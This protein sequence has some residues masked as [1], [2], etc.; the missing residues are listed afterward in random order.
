MT[1]PATPVDPGN[2]PLMTLDQV[3]QRLQ[4]SR[5]LLYRL[6][7]KRELVP[8]H[9]GRAIRFDP[10]TVDAFIQRLNEQAREIPD[11]PWQVFRQRRAH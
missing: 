1:L 9:L 7:R 4:V 3:L 2:R 10:N 11:D 5:T 8:V 6:M